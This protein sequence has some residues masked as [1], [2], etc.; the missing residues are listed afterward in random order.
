MRTPTRSGAAAVAL[1]SALALTVGAIDAP[2]QA[3]VPDCTEIRFARGATS[4]KVKGR[5]PGEGNVCYTIGVAEG[6]AASIR[7][8]SRFGAAFSMTHSSKG[9]DTS[10]VDAVDKLD[11]TTRAGVY[12]ISVFN[13]E[14]APVATPFTLHISVAAARTAKRAVA[15]SAPPG[16]ERQIAAWARKVHG[17][18]LVEPATMFF[19]DFTGD[20]APDALVFAYAES[21]GSAV[22]LRVALFRNN[23][24]SLTYWRD[25]NEVRGFEPRDVRFATGTVTVT[26]TVLRPTDPRCCPTGSRTWTIDAR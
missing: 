26:T 18:N 25:H 16:A 23:Q 6:Q 1:V 3:Q 9:H 17:A 21:G 2:A 8:K 20:G 4:A 11:F 12:T 10:A 14:P 15:N 24:G 19:G 22:D 13:L 7:L 5:A